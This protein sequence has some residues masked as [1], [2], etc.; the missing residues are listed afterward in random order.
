MNKFCLHSGCPE[1]ILSERQGQAPLFEALIRHTEKNT[2]NLHIPGH[3]QGNRI[4]EA[5]LSLGSRAFFSLDLT[6]LPGLDDLHN[7]SGAIHLAQRL[8]ADLY[9]ADRS[10]FLV[11]GTSTGIHALL[12][13]AVGEK[14]VIVPRNAHRSVLG[15][16]VLAGADP[17]YVIPELISE[18]GLD[19]G[20]TPAAIRTA[21]EENPSAAAIFAVSPNYYG[22]T[23]DLPGQVE[24]AHMADK[25]FLVDEAHGAHL[26]FHPALPEDAMAAGADAAVQST[27]KLGGSLTQ[28]SILHLKG[29]LIEQNGVAAA[30]RLLQTTSPSYLLM[31][32][33]DL[34]R[35]QLALRGKG[36]LDQAL[37]MARK[38]R[39]RLSIID[40]VSVLSPEHLPVGSRLDPTRLVISVRGLGLSGYQVQQL[41]A[42]RYCVYVEMADSA[43]VVA[44]VSI[45]TIWSDCE[46]LAHAMA[47]IAARDRKTDPIP[48]LGTP[49]SFNMLMK[50]RDAWF[51]KV[52]RVPL[53]EAR[54]RISAETIAV[55]PPGIPAVNP[56]EEITG[57]VLSYLADVRKMGLSCQG[58]SDPTLK[59][60]GVVVE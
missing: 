18:F 59:T 40:H 36:L 39:E 12:V 47:D 4:P 14:K 24:A 30:L 42:E 9:G 2:S 34:A 35:R 25:P 3:R 32:S 54:G 31:V 49:D 46:R 26:R 17:V 43:H 19:C 45:G 33:L 5:L 6:E 23:G 50:P 55:Y 27:H 52:R 41:L 60:I 44:I 38:L 8:A 11:N 13:A 15:G 37:E 7:P 20:V 28:S 48:L 22:I 53:D 16:L 56:G 10:F 57:D 1:G 58:P 51:A 21:L 29:S